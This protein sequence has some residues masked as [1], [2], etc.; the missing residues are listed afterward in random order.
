MMSF[1]LKLKS[2]FF[3][4]K[5]AEMEVDQAAGNVDEAAGSS[6]EL[7]EGASAWRRRLEVRSAFMKL[8]KRLF[9]SSF[10]LETVDKRSKRHLGV[11]ES[12]PSEVPLER[13]RFC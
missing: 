11:E 8:F 9:Q 7:S 10:P 6:L 12:R 5:M 1:N 13:V 4:A 2:L 3:E